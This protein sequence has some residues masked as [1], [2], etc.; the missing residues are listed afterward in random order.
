MSGRRWVAVVTVV[1]VAGLL[2]VATWQTRT[3]PGGATTS[4]G[5]APHDH[6]GTSA[7]LGD[8]GGFARATGGAD[9]PVRWVEHLDDGGPGSLREAVA[10]PG[11]ARVRFRPGLA[12]LLTLDA[13]LPVASDLTVDGRG[14]EVTIDNYGLVVNE[15]TNVVIAY[16]RFDFAAHWDAY[17]GNAAIRVGDDSTDVWIT[18][19]TFVGAGP[20]RYHMALLFI[21]GA[22]RITASWN[23]FE[24]WDRTIMTGQ[25]ATDPELAAD[26]ITLHHNLFLRTH[27]RNPL[28]RFARVHTYNN[29]L[30][31]FG[32]PGT[33]YGMISDADAQ[34]RSEADLFQSSQGRVAIRSGD[35]ESAASPGL[36]NHDGSVFVDIDPSLVDEHLPD[37][38]FRPGDFYDYVVDPPDD[39][40]RQALLDRAGWQPVAPSGDEDPTSGATTDGGPL[41]PVAWAGLVAGAFL[42]ARRVGVRR[43]TLVPAAVVATGATVFALGVA[44]GDLYDRLHGPL[45]YANATA[46]LFVVATAAALLWR[47]RV[48]RRRDRNLL[49]AAALLF[50]TVPVGATSRTGALATLLVLAGATPAWQRLDRRR[51]GAVVAGL[52]AAVALGI[53]V[54]LR[55]GGTLRAALGLEGVALGPSITER[56]RLWR[57]A[58]DLIR[59][60]PW[61]G[62]GPGRFGV[63]GNPAVLDWER[64]AHNEYLQ[65][66]AE[67][68]LPVL[69]LV[70]V[71]VVALFRDLLR[72]PD[73]AAL[74]GVALLTALCV[75]AAVDYVAHFP[76]VALTAAACLGA[77]GRAPV[78]PEPE[79]SAE[80][81]SS[82][83]AP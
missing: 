36:V 34:L 35:W 72:S 57:E 26:E 24:E 55:A 5:P 37:Q 22:A 45:G 2:A 69:V 53:A 19:C 25:S 59:A 66:A 11:P 7:S 63:A 62:V 20:G 47:E 33:G 15:A 70:L 27:Q 16:V 81:A 54:T 9:G 13:P 76:A 32:W 82:T 67:L 77:V 74:L 38:V 29:W 39:T 17:D 30:Y 61:T 6:P 1:L 31:E 50:A 65:V 60:A 12:G 41:T 28:A 46:A 58:L 40:L 56:V 49:L 79:R 51:A 73:P 68:G 8:S 23:R 18:Q 71:L 4:G 14:A 48:V 10:E 43:P 78:S 44:R 83:T 42:L 75:H 3:G 52:L 21:D 64:Y 80:W